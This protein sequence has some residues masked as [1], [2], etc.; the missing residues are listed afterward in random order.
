MEE[1][2]GLIGLVSLYFFIL[3][4]RVGRVWRYILVSLG[5]FVK[6]AYLHGCMS[7]DVNVNA[8]SSI[9]ICSVMD[10]RLSCHF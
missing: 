1:D 5:S 7:V 2:S 6:S 9:Y 10:G 4:I 8:P 3:C